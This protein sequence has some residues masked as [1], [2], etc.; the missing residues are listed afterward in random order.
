MK[1]FFSCTPPDP[2]D[3]NYTTVYLEMIDNSGHSHERNY[4]DTLYSDAVSI[5]LTLSDSIMYYASSIINSDR[6]FTF[7]S[8]LALSPNYSYQ[9]EH[10]VQDIQVFTVFDIDTIYKVGDNISD[11]VLYS[12][13]NLFGLYVTKEKA[14]KY[15]NGLQSE[16]ACTLSLFLKSSIENSKAQFRVEISLDDGSK[17]IGTTKLYPVI[18]SNL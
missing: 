16:P 11:S 17:L 9:P 2:F 3:I 18:P 6:L 15:T 12:I 13:D 4:S 5:E 14:I 10:L 8:A 1:V 7:E